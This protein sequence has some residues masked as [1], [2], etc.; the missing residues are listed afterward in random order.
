[1][2]EAQ[3]TASCVG[4]DTELAHLLELYGE[5]RERRMAK[6]A[7]LLGPR[8]I[9]KSKLL[10]ALRARARLSGGVVL[11]GRAERSS[12]YGAFAS[13][14]AQALHFLDEI[15][16]PFATEGGALGCAGGCH[17]L[18]YQHRDLPCVDGVDC[19]GQR[20]RFFEGIALL[21]AAVARVRAPIVLVHDLAETDQGTLDLVRSLLDAGSPLAADFEQPLAMMIATCLRTDERHAQSAR[22]DALL[23]H[24]A[25]HKLA[26]GALS[27]AGVRAL[28]S[29]TETIQQVL[30]CTGGAPDAIRRLL[31]TT[32]PTHD[33][34]VRNV[35]AGLPTLAGLAVEALAVRGKAARY[36][37][38]E[39]VL[40]TPLDPTAR[41][42][43]ERMDWLELHRE[44]GELQLGFSH[45]AE[46]TA[47]LS[48]L[49]PPR[50]CELHRAWLI[51]LD[52]GS[53][54]RADLVRHAL[55]AGDSERAVELA[56]SASRALS[57]RLASHEAA[58]L[59][60]SVL[61]SAAPQR[62]DELRRELVHLYRATGEYRRGLVHAR[63]L[64]DAS[65]RDPERQRAL[66]DLLVQAGELDQAN[67]ALREAR[68]SVN[69][70]LLPA[71]CADL[72]ALHAE[73]ALRRS[74]YASAERWAMQALARA[75]IDLR[76]KIAA[77]NTLGKIELARDARAAAAV[78]FELNAKASAEASLPALQSQA[79]TNLGYA[80]LDRKN[81]LPA[82]R[83]FEQALALAT[84]AGDARRRAV[85]TEALAVCAHLARDYQRARSHYQAA[86]VLL[87]RVNTP[88]MVAGA[89]TNLGELYLSL[90]ETR[91]AQDM[92]ELATQVGG[93]RLAQTLRSECMLLRG[94]VAT[95][96]GELSS[97][98]ASL[99]TAHAWMLA[100]GDHRVSEVGL[101]LAEVDFEEGDVA[102]A[103]RRLASLSERTSGSFAARVATLAARIERACSGDVIASSERA[104]RL[105]D[106]AGDDELRIPALTLMAR[107]LLDGGQAHAARQA[108]ERAFA[109]ERRL[110][111]TVPEDLLP[112]WNERR[113]RVELQRIA[114]VAGEVNLTTASESKLPRA[115]RVPASEEQLVRW[116]TRYPRIIGRSTPMCEVLRV[117]DRAATSDM[118]VLI[119]G[120]SGTG[121]ELVAEALHAGSARRDK[122]FIRMNCAAIVESL[123]LSELFGHERGAFTGAAFRR[124]G[125]FEAAHCGTLF[126][127]EIG[128][129]SPATQAALLRVLQEGEL[130]RVGGTQTIKVDVRIVA[131]THRDLEAMVRAGTFREDL[132]YRLRGITIEMPPLRA[133]R[134]DIAPLCQYLL[135][136]LGADRSASLRMTG[137]ALAVLMRHDWPGNVRELDN[138][139]RNA[140]LFCEDGFLHAEALRSLLPEPIDGWQE[141][142]VIQREA[143]ASGTEIDPCDPVYDRIRGGHTSLFEM[144]KQLERE[145]IQRA[146]RETSGN[147]TR[148]ASLLG[149]KRPRLSQL[150][151]EYELSSLAE[152]V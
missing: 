146:L 141:P 61:P 138:V 147:I 82:L 47:V 23:A 54:D 15:G 123:L 120:E 121:K 96:R 116:A 62:I 118:Q 81:P 111:T 34:H 95:A 74:D 132:Y 101:A 69:D 2:Q 127:D 7:V 35:L 22:L 91:R 44:Q 66:C 151:K 106:A 20:E 107:A 86:L 142:L 113:V 92:C 143:P 1:M 38:L 32:P 41:K 63:S 50:V 17:A 11:E 78:W 36:S 97:A 145:C 52:C 37:E 59:L 5:A 117:I 18:W 104:A 105:A 85:A 8:G 25:T 19:A 148:A 31:A 64:R 67:E 46:R 133:R 93:V 112:A 98:R 10:G 16:Q 128:D 109:A 45:N 24:E 26:V 58:E 55:G 27:E 43:L 60:E 70:C 4:R 126:L 75:E 83:L 122:P 12:A 84:Q 110:T 57:I 73:V 42:A 103:R 150:V 9:G 3:Q 49:A 68:A 88:S 136:G 90:G 39:R 129:I 53:A 13:I 14:V 94:R 76:T 140:S 149:M 80:T 99:E 102:A 30:A 21:L 79:C 130:E 77:R 51:A 137:D 119:R 100:H 56:L 28:L 131:A 29:S 135:S 152:R 134:E 115:A 40:D 89:A 72:E 108:V 124:R 65:P 48:L 125:R 33:E 144:K 87:R 6:L 71:L 114:R 139:L